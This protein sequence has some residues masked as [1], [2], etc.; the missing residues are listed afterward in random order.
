MKYVTTGKFWD[1]LDGLPQEVRELAD[2]NYALLVEN[3]QHPSLEL[4]RIGSLWSV[5]VGR[6]YR[7]L[8]RDVGEDVEWFWVGHHSVYDRLVENQ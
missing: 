2:K 5:R 1:Y 3:P 4:K 7:A 8:G 6:S